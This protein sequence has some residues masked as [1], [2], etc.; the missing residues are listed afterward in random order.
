MLFSALLGNPVEHSISNY[1]F[2][3][4]AQ[5]L[6]LEYAHLKINVP[7]KKDLPTYLQS[8]QRLGCIGVNITIPYKLSVIS[9]LDQLDDQAKAMGAVNTIV[10]SND[11]MIGYNTDGIGAYRSISNHLR[12]VTSGDRVTVLGAG[13][14]ARAI[15][16][17]IYQ[18]CDHITVLSPK[19]AELDQLAQDF[20]TATKQ[21]LRVEILEENILYECLNSTDFLINATPVGMHPDLNNSLINRE[22][23]LQLSQAR[24]LNNLFVFDAIF[25]PYQTKMLQIFSQSGAKVCSGLWMMIYQ[26]VEA[27][28]LWTNKDVS[29]ALNHNFNVIE[30]KLCQLLAKLD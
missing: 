18:H 26:A 24:S 20:H 28:Q 2:A 16:Y 10:I 6:G 15:I 19:Q 11:K 23:V 4:Y 7:T 8:L 21:P 12:P 14:A 27:F 1:L 5:A 22:K 3:E 9:C 25:N 13:G 29:Q 30:T 17:E